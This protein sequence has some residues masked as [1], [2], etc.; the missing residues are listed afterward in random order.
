MT[1]RAGAPGVFDRSVHVYSS[2]IEGI[3]NLGDKF[4]A[5]SSTDMSGNQYSE[6]ELTVYTIY[7]EYMT[8][9]PS[10]VQAN[11][12]SPLIISKRK[13]NEDVSLWTEDIVQGYIDNIESS[14]FYTNG[15]IV[16]IGENIDTSGDYYATAQ[17]FVFPSVGIRQNKNVL[18]PKINGVNLSRVMY[19]SNKIY[20]IQEQEEVLPD[21]DLFTVKDS[22]T[23]TSNSI[24]NFSYSGEEPVQFA[25]R[26]CDSSEE[27]SWMDQNKVGAYN[28][29][30]SSYFNTCFNVY[31]R[32]VGEE[33]YISKQV[34]TKAKYTFT[35][36]FNG[37][38]WNNATYVS[39]DYIEGQSI[40]ASD[41]LEFLKM[42]G[43]SFEG[44]DI[45]GVWS[46][47][48]G[49]EEVNEIVMNSNVT[50][51]LQFKESRIVFSWSGQS[52]EPEYNKYNLQITNERPIL[53]Q[54]G[55]LTY[56]TSLSGSAY[57]HINLTPLIG[58][59]NYLILYKEHTEA[60]TN[61]AFGK[62]VY[63]Y[64]AV[65]SGSDGTYA[66]KYA[67]SY[68]GAIFNDS[69]MTT[70]VKFQIRQTEGGDL[71]ETVS[72]MNTGSKQLYANSTGFGIEGNTVFGGFPL[73][74]YGGIVL[75]EAQRNKVTLSGNVYLSLRMGIGSTMFST[76]KFQDIKIF[77]V[78]SF[79]DYGS[80]DLKPMP[81]LTSSD[82]AIEN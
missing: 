58:T 78:D 52:T 61:A 1:T 35:L 77:K 3:V 71:V 57:I 34:T 81:I 79:D 64:N 15:N 53:A 65:H 76:N 12:N 2:S 25:V 23:S 46:A 39:Q 49:G 72:A 67:G 31:C 36:D 33:G 74:Q 13:I 40:S 43:L 30:N 4:Y 19:N 20:P 5:Y 80:T 37:K 42:Y 54:D 32:F 38:T 41:L 8:F 45:T 22:T 11:I 59:G 70:G 26:R 55:Y 73:A 68:A 10:T 27:L 16:M 50:V 28:S 75:S 29:Y 47:P 56:D 51:Y 18:T 69:S 63:A 62:A 44:Y 82:Y 7:G 66:D 48:S 21:P 6:T 24:L 17:K 14:P 60:G 9:S